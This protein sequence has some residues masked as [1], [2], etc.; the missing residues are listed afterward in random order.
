MITE[1]IKM[2]GIEYYNVPVPGNVTDVT[3][4]AFYHENTIVALLA[5]IAFLLLVI[6]VDTF[7]CRMCGWSK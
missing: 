6:V 2:S 7:L 5:I 1:M 4:V 3:F